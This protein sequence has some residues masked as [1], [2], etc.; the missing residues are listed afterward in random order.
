MICSS[1]GL[2]PRKLK[3][4]CTTGCF[5]ERLR[6]FGLFALSAHT[7]F[8]PRS[9][10][11]QAADPSKLAGLFNSSLGGDAQRSQE[12]FRLTLNKLQVCLLKASCA[13]K[14][15]ADHGC[16]V[17]APNVRMPKWR[18]GCVRAHNQSYTTVSKLLFKVRVF[19]HKK[20][21]SPLVVNTH[22]ARRKVKPQV[23]V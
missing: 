3:S 20:C 21:T 19:W 17:L 2:S 11:V 14:K 15:C 7:N 4:I 16:A 9:T 18:C 22:P 6:I 23:V 5:M 12:S 1:P 8:T 13:D 10:R